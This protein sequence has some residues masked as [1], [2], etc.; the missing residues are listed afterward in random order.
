MKLV[1]DD[2]VVTDRKRY[3]FLVDHQELVEYGFGIKHM[4][5][6][7]ADAIGSTLLLLIR[8]YTAYQGGTDDASVR[9]PMH[10]LQQ[11]FRADSEPG[12]GQIASGVP[13]LLPPGEED[14]I[15]AEFTNEP[16]DEAQE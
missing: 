9:V 6:G 10:E 2:D 3:C 15:D 13:G 5:E 16:G 12:Q 4:Q 8:I 14:I 1:V 11:S 7:G